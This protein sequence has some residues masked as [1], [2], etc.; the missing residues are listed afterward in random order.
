VQDAITVIFIVTSNE[1]LRLLL[2]QDV[3]TILF[4]DGF[5]VCSEFGLHAEG[6]SVTTMVC[7]V[8]KKIL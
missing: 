1:S 3:I 4:I 8:G 2:V 6:R 5:G 7:I